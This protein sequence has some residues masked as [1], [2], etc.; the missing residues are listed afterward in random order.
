[1]PPRPLTMDATRQPLQAFRY[2][3][4][5]HLCGAPT[6]D[7]YTPYFASGS[8][9]RFN[10]ESSGHYSGAYT[11]HNFCEADFRGHALSHSSG[12]SSS[13]GSTDSS[14]EYHRGQHGIPD[15]CEMS[16]LFL[17]NLGFQNKDILN[18]IM[19]VF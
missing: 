13:P 10:G 4:S 18:K 15:D 12:P 7:P 14:D 16:A 6:D 19:R 3:R 1:M 11:S 8:C 9:V 17:A 2:A 5:R